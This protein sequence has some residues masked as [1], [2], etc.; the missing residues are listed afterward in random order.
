MVFIYG[1]NFQLGHSG[2]LD[3]SAFAAYEDMVFVA[4][5]YRTNGKNIRIP[6][7]QIFTLTLIPVFGFA[8][9]RLVPSRQNLGFLDQR[10]GLDWV[11]KNIRA[12]G[13]DPKKVMVFGESAG[14]MAI[15]TL[16]TSTPKNPP[17]RA[18]STMS[19]QYAYLSPGLLDSESLY[20]DSLLQL[21]GCGNSSSPNQALACL[22]EVP[23]SSI[24]DLVEQNSLMFYP[25]VDNKTMIA[26]PIEARATGNFAKVPL[27]A[28]T[29]QN[30]GSVNTFG[31]DNFTAWLNQNF[32]ASPDIQ[33]AIKQVYPRED[34]ETDAKLVARVF[35][36]YWFL[37]V[38]IS[39]TLA[40]TLSS[41]LELDRHKCCKSMPLRIKVFLP[42][43]TTTTSRHLQTSYLPI[44]LS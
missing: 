12:F 30:E 13:G 35:T 43:T 27:L 4:F 15:D 2:N 5:N 39:S 9:P 41:N 19:G 1:G 6:L 22:K 37:C 36:D 26:H 31:N 38:S 14:A 34:G 7:A 25:A 44:I 29:M 16:I 42:G 11:Q 10:L 18:A 32:A 17:F 24:H 3:G 28:G 23:A 8:P 33:E 20:W 40:L 21:T